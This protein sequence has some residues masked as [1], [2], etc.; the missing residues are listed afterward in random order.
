MQCQAWRWGTE[1]KRCRGCGLG[2]SSGWLAGGKFAGSVGAGPPR[3]CLSV[4]FGAPARDSSAAEHTN[5]H[6]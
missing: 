5:T 1:R 3:R 4:P 2:A 6:R